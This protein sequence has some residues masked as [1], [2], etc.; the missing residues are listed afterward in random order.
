MATE[1]ESSTHQKQKKRKEQTCPRAEKKNNVS[2]LPH[3]REFYC[4]LENKGAKWTKY[5]NRLKNYFTAYNIEDYKRQKAILLSFVGEQMNDLIDELPPEQ[6]TPEKNETHFHK[7]I[8]AVQ[9]HFNPENNTEYKRFIFRKKKNNPNI[10]DFYQELKE[11]S[12]MC[13][14]TDTNAEIKFYKLNYHDQ[15]IRQALCMTYR[16]I[17]QQF[18]PD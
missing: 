10:E 16:T 3:Y 18:Q 1:K 4:E 12:A 17:R 7:L 9:N 6:I 15:K 11:A 14:F 8:L 5:V 2:A 13:H